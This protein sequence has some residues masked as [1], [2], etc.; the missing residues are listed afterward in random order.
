MEK[1]NPDATRGCDQPPTPQS[2]IIPTVFDDIGLDPRA[3]EKLKILV[4]DLNQH[5]AKL[6]QVIVENPDGS[7]RDGFVEEFSV[8][9]LALSLV[10]LLSH[11]SSGTRTREHGRLLLERPL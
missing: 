6:S 7:I 10:T 4:A 11:A 3:A 1:P 5:V 9:L 8:R 2:L